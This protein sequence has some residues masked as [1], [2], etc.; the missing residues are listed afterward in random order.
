MIFVTGGTGFLGRHLLRELSRTGE[1]VRALSRSK[2]PAKYLNEPGGNIE[3]VQGSILDVSALD[4]YMEGCNRVYH[5]AGMV[6]FESRHRDELMQ[7]N[8]QG[9]ANVVNIALDKKISKL[10]HVSSV[11]AI[12]RPENNE[13]VDEDAVW[14]ADGINSNYGISKYLAEKQ[15]WRG[16]AEG[17]N[18]VI[19]N[20]TIIIGDGDWRQGSPRFFYNIW[21]GLPAY[22][23]GGSGFVAAKDVAL[24]MRQLM[25]SELG[26]ER[27]IISAENWSYRDFL[28]L[29]A[30]RMQRKRPS[31]KMPSW[32][33]Q[34]LWREEVL[35]TALFH[36]NPIITRETAQIAQLTY[37]FHAG[38]IKAATGFHF[39]SIEQCVE[40][41]VRIFLEEVKAGRVK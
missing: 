12:G 3:W 10:L 7:M 26:S 35:R 1:P 33:L 40:E 29:I 28:F 16:I 18:A 34:L 15:I 14:N 13:D 41:T 25:Q 8:E 30:D 32:L 39:T 36:S 27:Y 4:K 23:H 38:K 17:L 24:I 20:P 31:I 5:C 22:T 2:S 21:K 19:V 9:T 6:S 11:A 37:R